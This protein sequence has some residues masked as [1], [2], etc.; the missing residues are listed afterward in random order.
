MNRIR[1]ML[2]LHKRSASTGVYSVCSANRFAIE[3]AVRQAL[4]DDSIAL[5][6]ATS[7]QVDQYG[8]YTGMTPLQFRL[9]VEE[10]A[11]SIG[12][13]P[14]KVVLGGDHLGPNTWRKEPADEAMKK[15]EVLIEAYVAGGFTKIHL[16]TSM[17]CADDGGNRREPLDDQVVADRAARLCEV[18]EATYNASA[19]TRERPVYVIGTEVPTPGG[20]REELMGLVP[21]SCQAAR[22]TIDVH[23]EAFKARG[24][25]DAWERVVAVVVQ[26]G[27][28]FGEATVV[29]YRP[30]R[31]RPLSRLIEKYEGLV[32]EAHSTD[33]QTAEALRQ[34]VEDHFAIL[35][36]G[37]ALTFAMR[38]AVFALAM[39]E[40][41]YLATKRGVEL[42]RVCEVLEEEMLREPGYWRDHYHGNAAE[43]AYARK[44]SFSDR[45]RYYWPNPRV[46]EA[47]NRLIANI[48]RNPPP[49]TLISQYLPEQYRAV[50]EGSLEVEAVAVIRHKIQRVTGDYS[51][52]CGMRRR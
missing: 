11:G 52:A 30:E 2:P 13:P 28:E 51:Y 7:N 3:A 46:S 24:L 34:M 18:A 12:F 9:F 48:N 47:L 19:R 32:Y 23:R 15:A 49:L 21:T 1:E 8:G 20:A 40:R 26:P 16:D 4:D 39:M 6:E 31:A 17:H 45:C 36:V 43:Q 38:E 29:D 14:E 25:R 33:Y 22:R 27:V 35:K 42:S 41:E 5:I 37:P 44:Y 50:R 10:I